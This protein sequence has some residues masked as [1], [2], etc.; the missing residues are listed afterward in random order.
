MSAN[1]LFKSDK[2]QRRFF[3]HYNKQKKKMTMHWKNTC[4]CVDEIVCYVPAETK[5]AQ[6]QPHYVLQGWANSVDYKTLADS[7]VLAIVT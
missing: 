5:T 1:T 4:I 3:Y 6:T 7:K 2:T